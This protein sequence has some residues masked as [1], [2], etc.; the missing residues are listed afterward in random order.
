MF[1]SVPR[2]KSISGLLEIKNGSPLIVSTD[3]KKSMS[4]TFLLR[5]TILDKLSFE[6]SFNATQMDIEEV[7]F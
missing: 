1:S 5:L 3:S 6:G 4:D 2:I 7:E